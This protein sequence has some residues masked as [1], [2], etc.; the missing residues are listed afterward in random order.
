[1]PWIFICVARACCGLFSRNE[2]VTTATKTAATKS[3]SH[4]R[5]G[6]SWKLSEPAYSGRML[7]GCQC[8]NWP[9]SANNITTPPSFSRHRTNTASATISPGRHEYQV[10]R[11]L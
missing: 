2:D 8:G 5:P 10:F 9:S 1:M 3:P 6:L 11:C 7:S 4:W